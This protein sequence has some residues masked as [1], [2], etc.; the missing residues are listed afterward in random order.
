MEFAGLSQKLNEHFNLISLAIQSKLVDNLKFLYSDKSQYATTLECKEKPKF[1]SLNAKTRKI[2]VLLLN[3]AASDIKHFGR[4]EG[5]ME[6]MAKNNCKNLE[7]KMDGNKYQNKLLYLICK[8]NAPKFGL[9]I[10]SKLLDEFK[11]ALEKYLK[12]LNTTEL[13]EYFPADV[14]TYVKQL[15]DKFIGFINYLF[16]E[17]IYDGVFHVVPSKKK[18]VKCGFL[19]WQIIFSHLFRLARETGADISNELSL[20]YD[21]MMPTTKTSAKSTFSLTIKKSS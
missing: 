16:S 18:T 12:L 19:K 20:I 6:E 14:D 17:I 15:S 2:L 3:N 10:N 11:P 7:A 9:N 21:S 8:F 5:A 1:L 13:K 4:F